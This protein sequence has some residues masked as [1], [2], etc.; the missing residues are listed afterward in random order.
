MLDF[1]RRLN[2]KD[3]THDESKKD[4]HDKWGYFEIKWDFDSLVFKG[5]NS[6]HFYGAAVLSLLFG[7]KIG[8]GSWLLWEIIDGLKP[9]WFMFKKTAAAKEDAFIK[10]HSYFAGVWRVRL[11]KAM[12]FVRENGLY[13]DKFSMQDALLWDLYGALVGKVLYDLAVEYEIVLVITETLKGVF[14]NL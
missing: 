3:S 9:W 10:E 5:H 8:Y 13:S 11:W 7:F 12:D 14:Q 6:V 1:K 4:T 2:F